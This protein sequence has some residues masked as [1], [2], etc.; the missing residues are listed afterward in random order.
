M[1][2]LAVEFAGQVDV[3]KLNV[4]E[5]DNEAIQV[6]YGMRGHPTAVVLDANGDIVQRYFGPEDVGVL[7][8][9]FTAV[10]Q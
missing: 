5:G 9:A 3:V 6:A 2:G 1:D 8:E 7:R 10:S 4:G